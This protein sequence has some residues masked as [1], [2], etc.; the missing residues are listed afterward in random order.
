M[1]LYKFFL[2]EI[3]VGTAVAAVA[4]KAARPL[5]TATVGA[6]L[7]AKDIAQHHWGKAV[8]QL[9]EIV[10]EAEAARSGDAPPKS[11]SKAK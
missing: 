9:G 11:G 3:L 6:G 8:G 10:E 4:F 7:V 1:T 2:K 5:L